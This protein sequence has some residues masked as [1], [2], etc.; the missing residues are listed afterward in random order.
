M[1]IERSLLADGKALIKIGKQMTGFL[2]SCSFGRRIS[3][4]DS[5][6]RSPNRRLKRNLLTAAC[7]MLAVLQTGGAIG[8]AQAQP[9][10]DL[11]HAYEE[12]R[13]DVH[14]FL[15]G[16]GGETSDTKQ[17]LVETIDAV[18][19]SQVRSLPVDGGGRI[20][21]GC[22]G[23]TCASR[24]AVLVSPEGRVLAV[25]TV[26]AR[27]RQQPLA[28]REWFPQTSCDASRSLTIFLP[29]AADESAVINPLRAWAMAYASVQTVEVRFL[30]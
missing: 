17:H 8:P 7:A 21:S 6:R 27:C 19:A 22:R 10:K 18:T 28:Q 24:G 29:S 11:P 20:V 15:S 25:A 13:D 14:A 12:V 3:L 5:L 30:D 4:E 1:H 23:R 26:S 9:D 16:K 2:R